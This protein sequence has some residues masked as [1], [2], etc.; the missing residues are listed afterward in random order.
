MH[1]MHYGCSAGAST[2]ASLVVGACIG[3]CPSLQSLSPRRAVLKYLLALLLLVT[4]VVK[5]AKRAGKYEC[6]PRCTASQITRRIDLWGNGGVR[7]KSR[8]A[9][10]LF[11]VW[12]CSGRE[13]EKLASL[14]TCNSTYL[15]SSRQVPVLHQNGNISTLNNPTNIY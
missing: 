10:W 12:R 8:V 13:T 1:T 2:A 14:V 4:V 11:A 5:D 7:D 9:L 3:S 15:I 6:R